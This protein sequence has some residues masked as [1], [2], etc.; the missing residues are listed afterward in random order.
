MILQLLSE[1][2]HTLTLT[3]THIHRIGA[4]I[5]FF[6]WKCKC[7]QLECIPATINFRGFF[8]YLSQIPESDAY[9]GCSGRHRVK[10][11]KSYCWMT[12][13]E[14]IGIIIAYQRAWKHAENQ[15]I[16]QVA[17]NKSSLIR[18][19]Y[20]IA[21]A[22][23]HPNTTGG[24]NTSSYPSPE[25]CMGGNKFRFLLSRLRAVPAACYIH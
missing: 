21:A 4:R 23:Q 13:S 16:R 25:L 24:L 15:V 9:V 7:K 20:A 22:K 14:T 3:N 2:R 10:R 8:S 1:F 6:P 12:K 18:C 19:M 5:E 17:R 11:M